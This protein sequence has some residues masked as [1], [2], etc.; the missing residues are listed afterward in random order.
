MAKNIP[1]L[2]LIL[3]AAWWAATPTQAQAETRLTVRIGEPFTISVTDQSGSTGYQTVVR[4]MPAGVDLVS[5]ETK[6]PEKN[7]PGAPATKVFTFVANRPTKGLL[8]IN[9]AR[10]WEK[11]LEWLHQPGDAAENEFFYYIKAVK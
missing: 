7:R 10:M 4:D 9:A 3:A 6:R 1:L 11:P 8:E 5:T 2:L